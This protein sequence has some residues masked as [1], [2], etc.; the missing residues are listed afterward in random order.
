MERRSIGCVGKRKVLVKEVLEQIR[1]AALEEVNKGS[2]L[3]TTMTDNFLAA[4]REANL[5]TLIASGNPQLL[6][7]L[8]ELVQLR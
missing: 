7:A 5:E 3:T 6:Q 4:V 2:L 1:C 8:Q